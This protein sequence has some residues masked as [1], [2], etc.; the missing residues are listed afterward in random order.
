[1][2]CRSTAASR[3]NSSSCRARP[4]ISA[5]PNGQSDLVTSK[6]YFSADGISVAGG[7][8]SGTHYLLDGGENLPLPFPDALQEFSVDTSSLSARYGM[9]AGAVVNTATKSGSNQLHGGLFEFV[10]NGDANARDYFASSQDSLKRNQFGGIVGGPILKDKLFGFF[11]TQITTI[12]T[13]PSSTISFTPTQAVLGGD[14]S[15]L[16]SAG[17]QSSGAARTII[18]PQTGQPFPNNQVPAS[19]L[20]QQALNL[21]K[22]VPVATDPCGKINYAIPE[23]Q[24]E[25][26]FIGRVDNTTSA[27]NSLFGRYFLAN[28]SSPRSLALPTSCWRRSAALGIAPRRGSSATPMRLVLRS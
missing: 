7:Q 28:Y 27:K 9:H 2:T 16:E 12:R 24:T 1:M 10:R 26:Q 3:P 19:R 20:N 23:P 8:A 25:Q 17:C 14:F 18:D 21:L 4:T 13:A 22:Y 15:Q 11:G 6:N 5:R